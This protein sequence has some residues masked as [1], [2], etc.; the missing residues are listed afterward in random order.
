MAQYPV[1]GETALEGLLK[2]LDVVDS[3]SY[4]RA[5]CEQILI[6]VG[7]SPCVWIDARL[8]VR[9]KRIVRQSCTGKT[10]RNTRLQYAISFYYNTTVFVIDCMVQ[11]VCH[12]SCKLFCTITRQQSIRIKGYDILHRLKLFDAS[13][14]QLKIL[15]GSVP[16]KGIQGCQLSALAFIAHPHTFPFVPLPGSVKQ[17]KPISGSPFVPVV[18][19]SDL[20]LHLPE[21]IFVNLRRL[22]FIILEIGKKAEEEVIVTICK[23]TYFKSFSQIFDVSCTRKH[24]RNDN[25]RTEFS[26]YTIRK[27]HAGQTPGNHKQRYTPVQESYGQAAG[28]DESRQHNKP[29]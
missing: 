15:C 23:E 26:G 3:F 13:C 27:I 29:Q 19:I 16:D 5:F 25:Q 9:H 12:N 18:E 2:S 28:T 1:L 20:L 6:H 10:C 22:F 8:A 11:R 7:N 4:K 17:K 24:G 21:Q 14:D